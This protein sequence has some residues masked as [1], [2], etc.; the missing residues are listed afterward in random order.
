M[1]D[2]ATDIL[3]NE[4]AMESAINNKELG[5]DDRIELIKHHLSKIVE[6][7]KM[8]DKWRTYTTQV[9]NND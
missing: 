3:K 7:E 6:L 5:I 2:L 9:N 8:I 4:E 1:T